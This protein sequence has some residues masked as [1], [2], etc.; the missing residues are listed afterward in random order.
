[1]TSPLISRGLDHRLKLYAAKGSKA[2]RRATVRRVRRFI[3]FCQRPAEQVGRRQVHEFYEQNAFSPSTQRSYY[4]AICLLWRLL[5]R[6]RKPPM[7]PPAPTPR[8]TLSDGADAS[9]S[10]GQSFLP[11]ASRT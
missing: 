9:S 6:S 1:M 3:D 7:P 11:A 2:S 8:A 5:G 4:Y 10:L